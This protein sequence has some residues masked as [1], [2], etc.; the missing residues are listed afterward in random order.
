M[1]DYFISTDG[2]DSTGDGSAATPW[3]TLDKA[4]GSGA[5]VGAT[6]SVSTRLVV[7]PGLYREAFTL[8]VTPSAGAPL[9]I[10]G[11]YDGAIF[12]A[13]GKANPKVGDIEWRA[14]TNAT[15]AKTAPALTV[16][17]GSNLTISRINFT[18]GDAGSSLGACLEFSG[19]SN[20]AISD[21]RF[22]RPDGN[23][24][25]L[26]SLNATAGAALNATVDRCAFADAV[27]G[28]IAF[29]VRCPLNPTNYDLAVNVRNCLIVHNGRGVYA[30]QSATG[31]GP[32][33]GY[34][35]NVVG[36]TIRGQAASGQGGVTAFVRS[37][38]P[39][40]ALLNV[41][42]SVIDDAV[43][44]FRVNN[45]T[46]T[47]W[48]VEDYNVIRSSTPR[49]NVTA[50]SNSLVRP[51]WLLFDGLPSDG[52]L[53]PFCEP[54]A[55]SPVLA[56]A[57]RPAGLTVDLFGRSRPDP[58]AAGCLERVDPAPPPGGNTYI[59]QTEG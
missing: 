29:G 15:T 56:F 35:V 46:S 5:G 50:G 44:A 52:V 32:G 58:C 45:G 18:G 39:A 14:W 48:V 10:V 22:R 31:T 16:S 36:C 7:E 33:F 37:G 11:D 8:G 43:C 53:R 54:E 25:F 19:F 13:A 41:S 9:E 40:Y 59:F 3:K 28:G 51:A 2:S 21:C 47:A 38:T 30:G 4:I 55:G 23:A 42:L 24:G 26:V 49:T 12:G 27:G 34:G 20:I 17:S 1:A 6:L 57:T